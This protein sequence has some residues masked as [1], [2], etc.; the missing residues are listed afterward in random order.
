MPMAEGEKKQ[1]ETVRESQRQRQQQ[2]QS[3]TRT[4][5]ITFSEAAEEQAAHL[6]GF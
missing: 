4:K 3:K 1:S 2:K 6:V 5:V